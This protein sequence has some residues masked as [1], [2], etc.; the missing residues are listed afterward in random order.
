MT[1]TFRSSL[2]ARVFTITATAIVLL[3]VAMYLLAVPFIQ[4]TVESVEERAAKTALNDAVESVEEI[5]RHLEDSQRSVL[6]ARKEELRSIIAIVASRVAWLERQV[7]AGKLAKARAKAMLLEELRQIKYGRSD[8]VWASDYHSRLVSHPDP[9]LHGI[10]FSRQRDVRGNLILAPMVESARR[11]NEGFHSYWWRRLGENTPI[12]KLSY[13][14]H[15]PAFELVIGTGI[16]VDDIQ[17][18]Y[19]RH[20][21]EAIDALRQ[22]L[23]NTRLAK[24]GYLYI[25]DPETVLIHPS[26]NAEGKRVGELMDP[27]T[28]QPITT[29]LMAVAEQP[30]GLRYQWDKPSD[31]GNYVYDKISW[32]RYSSSFGWYVCSSV[33]VDELDESAR[34]LRNRVLSVF[35]VTMLVALLMVYFLVRRLT[36]PLQHMSETARRVREGDLAARCALDRD[37]EIGVVAAAFDGMVD[38]MRDNITNL[39]TRVQERTAELEKANE[40]L[41]E[42]DQ[43]KSDFL[44]TVS[45]ELRTP[46]TSV[47]GF[48][49][50]VRKKLDEVVSPKVAGDDKAARAISQ[51]SGNMDII[52]KESERLTLLIN[53][54]L[55][56]AKLDAG[57][58]EW[59][60]SRQAPAQLIE[61]A[62]AV[63]AALADQQGVQLKQRASADLPDVRADSQRVQ[64][65]LINLISNAIKFAP[66]G[67]ITVDAVRQDGFVLFS[68]ADTGIGIAAEHL[69]KVF[70]KF[71]QISDTLTDKPQ[72][73][74]LGLSI[75]RQIVSQHG[76][77]I[78][79]ESEPGRGSTFHFTLPLG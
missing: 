11:Q 24:T 52:V 51:I 4:E 70:D 17:S 2:F 79:A 13:Y 68:V 16:Y 62:V 54:V 60:F 46:M 71:R 27:V 9:K 65:V 48:A 53:D 43:L 73:T 37:D 41:R 14:R 57:K 63:T 31:P 10:D 42:L 1:I 20:R 26:P 50:L 28:R 45:H 3:F 23:R 76:G 6:L 32:V 22:R 38:R 59:Q 64:Q 72:G 78:W 33:Y 30:D 8:Y 61:Q 40:E 67:E 7:G 35:V 18:A 34:I 75:C 58:V 66:G 56:S 15:F 47:V 29:M 19:D 25:F 74:G 39:D 44:S 12:E 5:H 49:K 36:D 21:A 55:D 77:R 69:D